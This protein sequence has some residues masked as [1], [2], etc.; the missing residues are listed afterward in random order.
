MTAHPPANIAVSLHIA[1]PLSA[2]RSAR[3]DAGDTIVF[4]GIEIEPVI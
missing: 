1:A 3:A 4:A 2:V